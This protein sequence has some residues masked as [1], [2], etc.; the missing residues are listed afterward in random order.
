MSEE[1]ESQLNII[2]SNAKCKNCG[3]NVKF[4]PKTQAL[5]CPN[6]DSR[7]DFD[8]KQEEIKHEIGEGK[9]KDDDNKHDSW[10]SEMKVVKCE[11]CGAEIML[12]GLEMSKSCPYC[13][14]DYVAEQSFLPGLKPDVVVPFMF[15]ESDAGDYFVKGMK[16]KFFAPTALKKKLPS[17]KIHGIYVPTFTFDAE[18]ET[19]YDGVLIKKEHHT[20]SKGRSYTTTKRFP[21]SGT[22]L[23]T[24]S[25]YVEETS[26]KITGK[27]MTDILPYKFEE[28]Y[29]YDSNFV[30]GY[31][32]EHYEDRLTDCYEHAK[33][34]M[35]KAIR[36]IILNKYDYTDVDYLN[37][38]VK[39]SNELYSYRMLPI[40][41]FEFEWKKNK[42]M[43]LMNGQTG[44][45][46]GGYP[47]SA[48]KIFF[49]VLGIVAL[50]AL[51]I[52]LFVF[53]GSQQ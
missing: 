11:T 44:K 50:V 35:K 13:G 37:M 12:S 10:A 53:L 8:K 21:I 18:S 46:G 43:V 3:S 51:I 9:L 39:F 30:R 49:T 34:G 5:V 52:F 22:Q 7:F 19:K 17:N 15:N 6:C 1:L 40:Y 24:H 16:K 27:Q 48:L 2:G 38:N 23:C 32:V 28:S 20:D 33:E 14:S 29:V 36:K 4:D 26:T 41:S 47:K 42:Y 31:S 25:N 45:V